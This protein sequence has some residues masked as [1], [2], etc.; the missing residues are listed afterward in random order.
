MAAAEEV[1]AAAAEWIIHAMWTVSGTIPTTEGLPCLELDSRPQD[2]P[3]LREGGYNEQPLPRDVP[4]KDK[5][6]PSQQTGD[7][8]TEEETVPEQ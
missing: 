8:D 2:A 3:M 6:T 1:L 4:V 5:K 7:L